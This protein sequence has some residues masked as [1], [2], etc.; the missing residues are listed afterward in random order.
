MNRVETVVDEV[1]A[2]GLYIILNAKHGSWIWADVT[3]SNANHSQIE[4]RFTRLWSQIRTRFVCKPNRFPEIASGTP[5]SLLFSIRFRPFSVRQNNL[6]VQRRQSFA[7][8]VFYA[9]P[10]QLH[11]YPKFRWRIRCLSSQHRAS[12]LMEV[13]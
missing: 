5:I 13:V 7:T 3:A 12:S 11:H 6:E 4:E 9:L 8:S 2:L 10:Q 1:L